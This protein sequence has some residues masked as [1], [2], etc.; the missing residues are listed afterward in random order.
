MRKRKGAFAA[1]IAALLL[2]AIIS[3]PR[4]TTPQ[5]AGLVE[6]PP[7]AAMIDVTK[8]PYS[9]KG[10]GI[11]DD[12]QALQKAIAEN[13]RKSRTLY[14]PKGTYLVSDKLS[15]Y[16]ELTLQGAGREFTTI[17]LKDNAP[18][19]G[20][21]VEPKAVIFAGDDNTSFGNSIFDL[22]VDTGSG[23]PGA[24]AI[25]FVASNQ[26]AVENV[27]MR[28]R[29][30]AGVTGLSMTRRY[31]GPLLVKNVKIEGYNY[32]IDVA[33]RQYSVTLQHV[34]LQNQK[35]AGIRNYRNQVYIEDLK[36]A[37]SVPAVMDTS[38]DGLV[39]IV[40]GKFTGGAPRASAIETAAYLYARNVTVSGYGSALKHRGVVR[41]AS[42]IDEFASHGFLSAFPSPA[43]SLHLPIQ[44][45]PTFHDPDM[46]NWANV[47]DYGAARDN[48]KLDSSAGIQAAIDS[49][50]ATIY[51]PLGVY[52]VANT[53]RVRGSVKRILGNMAELVP[54]SDHNL[55]SAPVFRFENIQGDFVAVERFRYGKNDFDGGRFSLVFE[56][57]S[58]KAVALRHLRGH[59]SYRG[60]SGAGPIHAEDVCCGR[61]DINRQ[62][63]WARQLNIENPRGTE[64][65]LINNGGAVWILG[66][67]TEDT[68]HTIVKT[69]GGGKTEVLGGTF[70]SYETPVPKDLPM[71]V[72]S[73]SHLSMIYIERPT[74]FYVQIAETRNGVTKKFLM[75]EAYWDK[76][77][78]TW[79]FYTGYY[80]SAVSKKPPPDIG[81]K[82]IP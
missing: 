74:W 6:F 71:I 17:R 12:T 68:K 14:L 47:L 36:S 39:V 54:K 79:N 32:G 11:A 8:P 73:E 18:G 28:T 62:S 50:K 76:R 48:P 13:E 60:L 80:Q 45:A 25:D 42:S 82:V 22:S 81:T 5:T 31:P 33:D 37:N 1:A 51:F 72:N 26:G 34:A 56:H 69:A 27:V 66:Y 46:R 4:T 23:N 55:S 2:G 30:G 19:Y 61:F 35:V 78:T 65:K 38:S 77:Y 21:A 57:A 52:Y 70:K 40:G 53:V 67:K 15:W 63:M 75:P 64:P 58:P 24:I 43:K 16:N 9:A 44:E 7:A 41:A 20:N 29:D 49:G 3:P 10:D 59:S